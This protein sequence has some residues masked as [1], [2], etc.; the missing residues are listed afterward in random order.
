MGEKATKGAIE[1]A[2]K[3]ISKVGTE[4]TLE[5]TRMYSLP[6]LETVSVEIGKAMY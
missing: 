5:K 3:D 6:L 1:T 4:S 2:V